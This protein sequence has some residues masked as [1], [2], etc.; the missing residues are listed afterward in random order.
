MELDDKH[1]PIPRPTDTEQPKL[2]EVAMSLLMRLLVS[3]A[4]PAWGIVMILLGVRN[5]SAWWIGT[6]AVVL[7]VGGVMFVGSPLADPIFDR[8]SV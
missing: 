4:L 2:P 1:E 7:G 3:L 5:G 6:G 8:R